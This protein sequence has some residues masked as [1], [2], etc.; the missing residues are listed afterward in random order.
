MEQNKLVLWIFCIGSFVLAG[1]VI[2]GYF[3]TKAGNQ[4]VNS[5][6]LEVLSASTTL[7]DNPENEFILLHFKII[8]HSNQKSLG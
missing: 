7:T 5:P 4:V 6:K 2:G 8:S 3:L 1:V